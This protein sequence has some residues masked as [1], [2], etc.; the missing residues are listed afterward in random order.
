MPR[1]PDAPSVTEKKTALRTE[2]GKLKKQASEYD[3]IKRN[4]ESILGKNSN[5]NKPLQRS[6]ERS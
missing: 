1:Y 4:V 6:A 2:Y 3:T 5:K